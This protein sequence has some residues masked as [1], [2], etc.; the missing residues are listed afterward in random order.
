MRILALETSTEYCSVALWQDGAVTEHCELV[1]Q[2]H[3]ELLLAML[4]ALLE[5]SGVKLAQLDGIAFGM[6]PGSHSATEQYSVEVSSAST[7]IILKSY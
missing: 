6:G 1:G 2:K 4:D 3:S 7:R 5:K